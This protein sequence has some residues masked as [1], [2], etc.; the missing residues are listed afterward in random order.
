MTQTE[1]IEGIMANHKK[2]FE[3]EFWKHEAESDS[4][5]LSILP[6]VKSILNLVDKHCT[7]HGISFARKKP[8]N[9]SKKTVSKKSEKVMVV[10]CTRWDGLENQKNCAHSAYQSE[11]A[12][13]NC[14]EDPNNLK[15]DRATRSTYDSYHLNNSFNERNELVQ[16]D[17]EEANDSAIN[18]LFRFDISLQGQLKLSSPGYRKQSENFDYRYIPEQ[19]QVRLNQIEFRSKSHEK[20]KFKNFEQ[21]K[22]DHAQ[23]ESAFNKN[24]TLLKLVQLK[25]DKKQEIVV[26]KSI[27]DE[28][29]SISVKTVQ[30]E[31]EMELRSVSCSLAEQATSKNFDDRLF[32]TAKNL[33]EKCLKNKSRFVF[34][35]KNNFCREIEPASLLHLF[36]EDT[37]SIW[38]TQII[39]ER[40]TNLFNFTKEKLVFRMF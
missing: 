25:I 28:L 23:N 5:E 8:K 17:K 16:V 35:E 22:Q 6:S 14:K 38:S 34:A 30:P 31:E 2:E 37:K 18:D 4:E 1:I 3:V 33:K 12:S 36:W 39:K 40:R 26:Q 11:F 27:C 7:E 20:S 9:K 10:Q 19:T 21:T 32:K 15:Q 13:K 29:K 24:E